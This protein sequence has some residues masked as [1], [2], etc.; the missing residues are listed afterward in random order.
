MEPSETDATQVKTQSQSAA[1]TNAPDTASSERTKSSRPAGG[2]SIDALREAGRRAREQDEQDA[3]T[4]RQGGGDVYLFRMEARSPLN[5]YRMQIEQRLRERGVHVQQID[6]G[7]IPK[8]LETPPPLTKTGGAKKG[9]VHQVV[10]GIIRCTK[11]QR[12]LIPLAYGSMWLSEPN[13]SPENAR[14]PKLG[15]PPRDAYDRYVSPGEQIER[16]RRLREQLCDSGSSGRSRANTARSGAYRSDEDWRGR[17]TTYSDT[18]YAGWLVIG[19]LKNVLQCLAFDAGV[20]LCTSTRIG[21]T[22]R[23]ID[24]TVRGSVGAVREFRASLAR[25][26]ELYRR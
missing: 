24:F 18:V 10:Q 7:T 22:G 21:V 6:M 2:F 8:G 3:L 13:P 19:S 4:V 25:R 23:A 1:Q 14:L 17:D 11:R 16:L 26:G 12:S 20:T 15:P 9:E 5:H